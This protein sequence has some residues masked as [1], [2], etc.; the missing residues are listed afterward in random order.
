MLFIVIEF[1]M[2]KW[3]ARYVHLFISICQTPN[4]A[5]SNKSLLPGDRLPTCITHV[6]ANRKLIA[7]VY[8]V[9]TIEM[10]YCVWARPQGTVLGV[11]QI[12]NNEYRDV[13][14]GSKKCREENQNATC[15]IF[16]SCFMLFYI[17]TSQQWC[18]TSTQAST[19]PTSCLCLDDRQ[20]RAGQKL[21]TPLSPI[22]SP[23]AGTNQHK[24]P[25][26]INCCAIS[27]V[28]HRL[29]RECVCVGT[30]RHWWERKHII[31]KCKTK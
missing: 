13:G 27:N 6:N 18:N 8:L 29:E 2:H 22:N 9:R 1:L 24:K 26:T 19:Q 12:Y 10:M 28:T 4:L 20:Q 7:N 15:E 11:L 17:H 5:F 23:L 16:A 3:C 30:M 25:Y 31:R 21:C 14:L